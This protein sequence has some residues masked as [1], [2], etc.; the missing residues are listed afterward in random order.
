MMAVRIAVALLLSVVLPACGN[1]ITCKGSE[2]A[3]GT[4]LC[5]TEGD[6]AVVNKVLRRLRDL[7]PEYNSDHMH[8]PIWDVWEDRIL[9]DTNT[10][11]LLDKILPYYHEAIMTPKQRS[12]LQHML[13]QIPTAMT[14]GLILESRLAANDDRIDISLHATRSRGSDQMMAGH[15]LLPKTVIVPDRERK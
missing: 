3:V 15:P 5:L 2:V 13:G 9:F 8:G 7:E 12:I 4:H 10:S 6:G 11:M 14:R 1:Q